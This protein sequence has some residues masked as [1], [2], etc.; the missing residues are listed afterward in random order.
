MSIRRKYS[1]T[2]AFVL[3]LRKRTGKK[4]G[5]APSHQ[6][7][8]IHGTESESRWFTACGISG[9]FLNSGSRIDQWL[10]EKWVKGGGHSE[11]VVHEEDLWG[12][13]T[14]S[15]I[16]RSRFSTHSFDEWMLVSVAD[17]WASADPSDKNVLSSCFRTRVVSSL[18]RST[19]AMDRISFL[20]S[21]PWPRL[22]TRWKLRN[23]RC[24][25]YSPAWMLV[26]RQLNC[27]IVPP[28]T[29]VYHRKQLQC[30]SNIFSFHFSF[31]KTVPPKWLAEPNDV[32]ATKGDTVGIDC[33]ATGYPI[34]K[35][36]WKKSVSKWQQIHAY[37][38]VFRPFILFY[39]LN[40]IAWL[41]TGDQQKGAGDFVTDCMRDDGK[42]DEREKSICWWASNS[43]ASRESLIELGIGFDGMSAWK[44]GD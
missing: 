8:S 1:L 9:I 33:Q 3:W 28:E 44:T 25:S 23:R 36:T 20:T 19:M 4:S 14:K 5:S 15:Q 11:E 22:M 10:C 2:S 38:I 39:R 31:S 32:S 16:Q 18:L 17:L 42:G 24:N 6:I 27:L 12:H 7:R 13:E 30:L 29:W 41:T 26:V 35:T 21:N 34:P 43:C 40:G 37:F